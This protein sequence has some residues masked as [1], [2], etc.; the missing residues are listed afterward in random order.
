[1][2][3]ALA[4]IVLT[5]GRYRVVG[6]PPTV[7]QC[8]LVAA[9]HTSNWD[10]PLMMAM[11]WQSGMSLKWLGKDALFRGP[12]GVFFRA[13]GGISVD[14]TNA[15]GMVETLAKTFAEGEP[16]VLAVPA[17]GTRSGGE[18][19]KSGFHRIALAA[20]VPIQLSFLDGPS[21]TG[22]FGPSIEA[23][24]DLAHD[25]D[26]IRAFYH[27]KAGVK[28]ANRTE[29]RLRNELPAGDTEA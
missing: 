24:D 12:A 15:A 13:L 4:R 2:K 19:W 23:T 8:V 17:E 6:D 5:L 16:L 28:P 3:S 10:F 14:R 18:F 9:P 11:A 29:P 20:S 26:Q 25:M 27:D 21:R 1:V 22:G 7:N